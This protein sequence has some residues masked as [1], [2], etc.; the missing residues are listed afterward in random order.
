MRS[1]NAVTAVK[2]I[3]IA[4]FS[5]LFFM[6]TL[7]SCDEG[8]IAGKSQTIQDSLV[9]IFPTWQS[10]KI[11]VGDNNMSMIVVIGDAT[12]YKAP[13]DVKKA[14]AIELGKMVLRLW[15]SHN[16][17]DKGNLIVTSDTRNISESPADGISIPI[18]FAGLKAGKH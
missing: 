11:K 15:G 6:T 17:F 16:Y 12:F 8:E 1:F 4:L 18:D 9:N 13:D 2:I 5:C 7:V 14:K 10:V 3:P